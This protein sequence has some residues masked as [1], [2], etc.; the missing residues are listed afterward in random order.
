MVST[1]SV[2]ASWKQQPQKLPMIDRLGQ[3]QSQLTDGRY[4]PMSWPCLI[5]LTYVCTLSAHKSFS[6]A[7]GERAGGAFFSLPTLLDDGS[8]SINKFGEKTRHRFA[9]LFSRGDH[10]PSAEPQHS[11]RPCYIQIYN[12]R[13]Q[14]RIHPKRIRT[15]VH[16]LTYFPLGFV[17]L[18]LLLLSVGLHCLALRSKCRA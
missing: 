2:R 18:F 14:G 7:E 4:S 11:D 8:S 17:C 15:R 16:L 12:G 13:R 1:D 10:H 9:W 3:V 5:Q 6:G